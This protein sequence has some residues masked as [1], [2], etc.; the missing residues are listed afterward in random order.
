MTV[1]KNSIRSPNIITMILTSPRGHCHCPPVAD[2]DT[3]IQVKGLSQ[4]FPVN[5]LQT[6]FENPHPCSTM[7]PKLQRRPGQSS[8][9]DTFRFTRTLSQ[10]VPILWM[11]EIQTLSCPSEPQS[12]DRTAG[13]QQSHA[14][15]TEKRKCASWCLPST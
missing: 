4:A 3:D 15:H 2:V 1:S 14:R 13:L 9:P 7:S 10:N 12:Q 11:K 6:S 8:S 5:H